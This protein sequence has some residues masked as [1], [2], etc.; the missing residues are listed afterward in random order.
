MQGS[1]RLVSQLSNHYSGCSRLQA[2]ASF[3][4]CN[5]HG[6]PQTEQMQGGRRW[7]GETSLTHLL[8]PSARKDW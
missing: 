4:L 8:T 1:L 5:R 2:L 7:P 6:L 3:T